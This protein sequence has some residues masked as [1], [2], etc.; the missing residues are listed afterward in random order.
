MSHSIILHIFDVIL[1]LL[2]FLLSKFSK[3]QIMKHAVFNAY[4]LNSSNVDVH[5]FQIAQFL[6]GFQF[7]ITYIVNIRIKHFEISIMY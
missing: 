6:Y 2:I 1:E 7:E 3:F 5:E 4:F